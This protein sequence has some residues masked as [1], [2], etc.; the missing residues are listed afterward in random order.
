MKPILKINPP[1]TKKAGFTRTDLIA[2]VGMVLLLGMVLGYA[3]TGERG[4]MARC[5]WNLKA[6]GKAMHGYAAEHGGMLPPAAVNVGKYQ[7]TWD[8]EVFTY[9]KPGLA[10]DNN[11]E[12][13]QIVPRYF[14]C[15]SDRAAHRGTPRSY[16]M[17]SND[18]T[19]AHWPADAGTTSGCGLNWDKPAV[20]RLLNE[21]ALK[22][23]ES[24]PGVKLAGIPAPADTV[25]LTDMIAPDNLMGKV[26]L[27]SISGS[28][29]Q[30]QPL[31][32][33]GMNYHHGGFNYLM[34]DGH[35]EWLSPLQTG[36]IDGTAG[37][38]TLKKGD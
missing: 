16:A 7:S 17:G 33:A 34:V 13:A 5:S 12:L 26:P 38:W 32:D 1:E 11:A 19:A 2:S 29:Q 31:A 20:L 10:Q 21:E 25:L 14:V 18:M 36:A 8:L 6:L 3:Y 35:V 37:I 23:P 4:R 30:R 24:L 27:A 15:P 28:Q 9:L 22:K